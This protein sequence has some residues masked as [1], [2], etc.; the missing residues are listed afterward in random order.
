MKSIAFFNNKGGVGKTSLVYHLAWMMSD[1][2]LKVLVADLDP[3]ANVSSMFLSDDELGLTWIGIGNQTILDIVKP[4]MDRVGDIHEFKPQPISHNISLIVGDLSLSKF[5]DTLSENWP[6]CSD[7]D[8]GAFRVETAFGRALKKATK[9]EKFDIV[10]IDVGPSLGAINRAALI[11][12]D[13]VVVPLSADLF[14]IKGLENVGPTLNSWRKQWQSRRLNTP[15]E[16][17]G[18]F[19]DGEM[20][21]IGYVVS[22]YNNYRR[23]PVKAFQKWLEKAPIS[24]RKAIYN[25]ET[26]FDITIDNDPYKLALLKDYRSLMPM[27]QETRK[28][29]F[30]LTPA[31]G[32]IGAHQGAVEECRADF[33]QLAQRILREVGLP[34]EVDIFN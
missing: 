17:D 33:Y 28:P 21:P 14:A 32:A 25:Q 11:A 30:K 26:P 27:A 5:E 29:M 20:R 3:Q 10:L 1:M 23:G 15:A 9:V 31:D 6:K 34:Q 18:T 12:S 22:R 8:V 16:L 19:P 2:G 24:Y 7:G 4:L 13:F